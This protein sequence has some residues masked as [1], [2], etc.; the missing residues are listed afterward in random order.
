MA[1]RIKWSTH[2]VADRISILDYWY[3]RIGD[4]KYSK[5]LDQSLKEII[6]KLADFPKLGRQLDKREERFFVKDSYQIFYIETKDSIELLHI[7]DSRRNP[8]DLNL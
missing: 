5:K 7:W 3:Q 1:K 4:K 8:D 2:V 6:K